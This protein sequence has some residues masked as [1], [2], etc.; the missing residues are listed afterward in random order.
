MKTPNKIFARHLLTT[1]K[2]EVGQSLDDFFLTLTKLSKDCN[3][4]NVTGEE[5][6]KQMIRDAFINGITSH[7]IRQRLLENAEL[8][9]EQ[10]FETART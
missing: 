1:A 8:L 9:L 4:A 5:Y 3:F 7:S 6:R 10:A 2:Q